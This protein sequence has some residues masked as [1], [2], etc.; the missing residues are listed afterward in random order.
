MDT[1]IIVIYAIVEYRIIY[2]MHSNQ[3]ILSEGGSIATLNIRQHITYFH[4]SGG[5]K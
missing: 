4:E 3:Y 5:K 1:S 2:S